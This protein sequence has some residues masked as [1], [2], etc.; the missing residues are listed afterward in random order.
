MASPL[1]RGS[2]MGP[3]SDEGPLGP[4]TSCAGLATDGVPCACMVHGPASSRRTGYRVG[5]L[6]TERQPLG[7]RF[8]SRRVSPLLPSGGCWCDDADACGMQGKSLVK[9]MPASLG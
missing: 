7:S 9:A 1:E 4:T 5:A 6:A 2:S 3:D 8:L